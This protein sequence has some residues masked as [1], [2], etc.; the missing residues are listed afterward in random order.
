MSD[1]KEMTVNVPGMASEA[2]VQKVRAA[3]ATLGGIKDKTAYDV[4][5]RT[6]TVYYDSMVI[7][8]KNIEIAIAEAGYDANGIQAIKKAA[9]AK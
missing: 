7:A 5:S 6:V 8:H 3:L 1:V 9:E 2:D 4:A